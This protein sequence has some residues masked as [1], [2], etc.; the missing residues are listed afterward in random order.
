MLNMHIDDLT[1]AA[2]SVL[3]E[4]DLIFLDIPVLLFRKVAGSTMSWTSHVG[5]AF[6]DINGAWIVAEST[7]PISKKTP[8]R[9]Y[10]AKSSNYAFEVKRLRRPL[11]STE[12]RVLK[13]KADSMLHRFY[14]LGFN[15]DSKGL[16]CSKFVYLTF[17][18]IGTEVGQVVTFRQLRAA[19]PS[20]PF[21]FW[22]VWF[23]GFIPWDRRTVTPASQLNDPEFISV[24]K[25]V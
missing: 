12:V 4:G 5:I 10:L 3:K 18:S 24:L 13:Q 20:A 16:F 1:S 15:F 19:H 21:K 2:E 14:T 7:F 8:L 6:K 22:K 11:T 25:G 17:Q 9:T 23:A